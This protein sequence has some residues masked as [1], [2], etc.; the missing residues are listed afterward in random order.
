M[1]HNTILHFFQG[2]VLRFSDYDRKSS[3]V[4]QFYVGS[5]M[6]QSF[7]IETETMIWKNSTVSSNWKAQSF[8]LEVIFSTNQSHGRLV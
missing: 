7:I 8:F 3:I 4:H 2:S 6:I 5:N 1:T